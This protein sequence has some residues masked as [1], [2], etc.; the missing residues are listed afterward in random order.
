MLMG[1]EMALKPIEWR[2]IPFLELLVCWILHLHP[3]IGTVVISITDDDVDHA[4][5]SPSAA[6]PHHHHHH[7]R[8]CRRQQQQ[9][10]KATTL[11]S[12][13]RRS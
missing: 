5:S 3:S 4:I 8:R 9:K 10:E 6:V 13:Q 2:I 1:S 11:S 7:H 12:H